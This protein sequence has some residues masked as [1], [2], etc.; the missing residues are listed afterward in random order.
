MEKKIIEEITTERK[1]IVDQVELLL[2]TSSKDIALFVCDEMEQDTADSLR[3]AFEM[4]EDYRHEKELTK[5]TGIPS[6]RM[7]KYGACLQLLESDE[8]QNIYNL[9]IAQKEYLKAIEKREAMWLAFQE[10]ATA[11]ILT[12]NSAEVLAAGNE[13]LQYDFISDTNVPKKY[14]WRA[15]LSMAREKNADVRIEVKRPNGVRL[16][17]T[18][19]FC[20]NHLPVKNGITTMPYDRFHKSLSAK[21]DIVFVFEDGYKVSG[22]PV[23]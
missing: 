3:E 11:K 2:N 10:Q 17:G 14:Q 16:D 4:L 21:P 1:K 13:Y 19:I 22:H 5:E 23:M 6:I 18:L 15:N 7:V 12:L 8:I 9:Y 20:E